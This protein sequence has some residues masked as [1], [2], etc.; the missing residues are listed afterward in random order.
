MAIAFDPISG[1]PYDT[2][3]GQFAGVSSGM[4]NYPQA[5][6]YTDGQPR[7][8]GEL[9]TSYNV[10]AGLNNNLGMD[11]IQGSGIAGSFGTETGGY[12]QFIQRNS[13]GQEVGPGMGYGQWETSGSA[14]GSGRGDAF[15]NYARANGYPNGPINYG[16]PNL[17]LG[18][19]AQEFQGQTQGYPEYGVWG[20]RVNSATSPEQ[21][22]QIFTQ[23]YLRPSNPHMA[24][25]MDRADDYYNYYATQQDPGY[26]SGNY[27][28]D[29]Y[30]GSAGLGNT[31]NSI[32]QMVPQFN[33][34]QGFQAG[35]QYAKGG[36]TGPQYVT[37]SGGITRAVQGYG[38]NEYGYGGGYD[39][40]AY[41]YGGT[42]YSTGYPQNA[43][44]ATQNAQYMNYSGQPDIT[45]Y[46]Y[47][48]SGGGGGASEWA[49][50]PVYGGTGSGG[51]THHDIWQT[52]Q[53]LSQG[54]NNIAQDYAAQNNASMQN[55]SNY[56]LQVQQQNQQLVD[57]NIA[58]LNPS[59]NSGPLNFGGG[60]YNSLMGW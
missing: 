16:D 30:N 35:D 11:P 18:Y 41:G 57:Q 4:T 3:S 23:S 17:N 46:A 55:L 50:Y 31:F 60:S 21:A 7:S 6:L 19:F 44:A 15:I 25:R 54:L 51:A 33:G 24:D 14:G 47:P 28:G 36:S 27:Y 49:D 10:I 45:V 53:T 56:N 20:Q 38:N 48:Q 39:P 29:T 22:A 12:N 8:I 59:L 1:Q 13:L 37:D 42:N 58:S 32:N 43:T 52:Q 5:G 26:Y 34:G 9:A 40:Q 2:E